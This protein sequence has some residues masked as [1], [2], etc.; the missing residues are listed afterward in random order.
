MIPEG[1]NWMHVKKDRIFVGD[2]REGFHVLKYRR[3]DNML[4]VIADESIPRWLT[5]GVTLDYH[6]MMGA[7]KF[8][9]VWVGRV[10]K[11]ARN[12]EAGDVSGLR[13]KADT[14]YIQGTTPKMETL[15][16][17]H[18]GE[19]ITAL[20]KTALLPGNAEVVIGASLM[21]GINCFYPMPTAEDV[22]F[23]HHL[24]MFMRAELPALAGN[25]HIAY[26]SYY[27]PVKCCVDGDLCEM[28]SQLSSEKQKTIAGELD[29]TPAEIMKKLEDLRNRIL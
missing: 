12:E 4:Y 26:R 11:G 18:V 20:E 25:E 24:E 1:I 8:D 19:T 10:P 28:F 9:N 23:F 17:F 14:S 5:A 6:T 29:R 27:H 15:V 21:G 22:D 13:L 3:N 16:N 7:D 2:I